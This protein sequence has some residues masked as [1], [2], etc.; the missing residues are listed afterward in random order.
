[1]FADY[2]ILLGVAA[3]AIG[4][5][6]YVPYIRDT[7]KGTTK[8]HVFSW[9]LWSLMEAIVFFAQISKGGGVGAIVTGTGA[10][11]TMFIA[12]LAWK[13]PDKQITRWDWAAFAG[14]VSGIILWRVTRD[15]L[16]AVI[17]VSCADAL[18]YA[19][20]YRKA[21]TKPHEETLIEYFLAAIKWLISIFALQS[22]NLTTW[23]YPATLVFTNGLFVIISLVRRKQ[24]NVQPNH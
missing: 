7:L 21:W 2:K 4:F 19:P 9:F 3:I 18:A 17:F 5:I 14:A 6:G 1:M 23:L 10:V 8:P 24:L 12:I 11:V 16:L 15:P 22:L 13:T 20:T